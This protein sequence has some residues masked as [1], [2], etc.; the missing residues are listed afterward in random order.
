[1][2]SVG[3]NGDGSVVH[4]PYNVFGGN[5]Q[6]LILLIIHFGGEELRTQTS[7]IHQHNV[8]KDQ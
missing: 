5:F 1:M 7:H 4:G 6:P 3:M 2:S 8:C